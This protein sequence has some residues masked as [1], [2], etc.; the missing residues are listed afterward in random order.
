MMNSSWFR[1]VGLLAVGALATTGPVLLA[2]ETA[3]E[4]GGPDQ[5]VLAAAG[6]RD[7]I[8]GYRSPLI[9]EPSKDESAIVVL[10]S[11]PLARRPAADRA[12]AAAQLKLEQNTLEASLTGLGAKVNFRYQN[13]VNGLAIRIPAGRL[14][15]VA[16]LPGVKAVHPVTYM[17]PAAEATENA[18]T[19]LPDA[20]TTTPRT[21]GAASSRPATI[22]LIDAGVHSEHPWLGGGIGTTRLIVG[23]ADFV[24]GNDGPEALPQA[25]VL[26]AHGTEMASLVLASDAITDL[27]ADQLPRMYAYRVMAPERVDGR[28]RMVARSDR[29]LAAMDRAVDPDGDHNL[30][31]HA[32]VILLGVSRGAPTSGDEP[33]REAAENADRIGTVVV[34]PAG[35]DGPSGDAS[36][37]T[38]AGPAASE[39]VLTVGA[40]GPTTAPRT[41]SLSLSIGP[42]SA[43]LSGLP[44]LGAKPSTG[45]LPVVVLSGTDGMHSGSDATDYVDARGRSR[46]RGAVVVVARGGEGIPVKARL[47]AQAGARALVVWD[48]SGDG[49]FP[50]IA[51]DTVIPITVVGLG[52][53]QGATLLQHRDLKVSIAEDAT[54]PAGKRVA[55]FSS[56]GPTA[57]GHSEPDVIAPG[58]DVESAYPGEG[59]ELL[60]ARITGTSPA[61]A[62]VAAAVLRLRVDHP[63]L[64]PAQVRSLVVQSADPLPGERASAQ[65]A[66]VIG[67]PMRRAVAVEPSI[68]SIRRKEGAPAGTVSF[69]V[70]SLT[71]Q[72]LDL[73]AAIIRNG[74]TV[75]APG[76]ATPLAARGRAAMNVT[77]PAGFPPSDSTLVLIDAD[78]RVVASAPFVVV[79]PVATTTRLTAPRVTSTTRPAQVAVGVTG[80]GTAR[81]LQVW[82]V[83]V[84][85]TASEAIR[86]NSDR[87]STEWPAGTYRFAVTRRS[88]SGEDV[89]AGRYRVRVQA[90]APDGRRLTQTG[91]PFALK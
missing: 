79:P 5:Q 76:T 66:G 53:E 21:P 18:G 68:V 75:V 72:A 83:P 49:R 74:A 58:V 20:G 38:V 15:L 25:R 80:G 82:L 67:A 73:R 24:Q 19:P 91:S 85:G 7:V 32:S 64:T 65:G 14:S 59:S 36:T 11:D 57:E 40:A 3:Q 52:R 34:A 30:D 35:N 48:Q 39:S 17:A 87:V 10:E 28:S 46:V 61:A 16:A 86:M 23:G 2:D 4:A 90:V 31:D 69:A 13:V 78:D 43:R 29:V 22:A 89:P 6:W 70:S 81:S 88:A 27:P 8:D 1:K 42:A 71:D 60:T 56:R 63:D 45:D 41:G 9:P 47:A 84:G 33:V 54:A 50:G 44:L 62:Q 51:A 26:E 12:D 37:G 55:S 77:I